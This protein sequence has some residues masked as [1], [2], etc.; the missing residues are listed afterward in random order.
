ML[1]IRTMQRRLVR[2]NCRRARCQYV[3]G[4][5]SQDKISSLRTLVTIQDESSGWGRRLATAVNSHIHAWVA[6]VPSIQELKEEGDLPR[7]LSGRADKGSPGLFQYEVK[8]LSV[9]GLYTRDRDILGQ[10]EAV[11]LGKRIGEYA[12]RECQHRMITVQE[13]AVQLSDSRGKREIPKAELL[14]SLETLYGFLELPLSRPYE[15]GVKK[16]LKKGL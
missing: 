11:R 4:L 3:S 10:P 5:F 6:A 7:Q 14:N 13:G 8:L 12:L 1:G 9:V 2:H 15:E 16:Y